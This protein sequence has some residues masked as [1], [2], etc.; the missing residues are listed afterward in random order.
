MSFLP[1]GALDSVIAPVVCLNVLA[2][3]GITAVALGTSSRR[4]PTNRPPSSGQE[5]DPADDKEKKMGSVVAAACIDDDGPAATFSCR[6]KVDVFEDDR[7]CAAY[8]PAN[9]GVLT[10]RAAMDATGDVAAAL[11]YDLATAAADAVRRD[12]AGAWVPLHPGPGRFVSLEDLTVDTLFGVRLRV[13]LRLIGMREAHTGESAGPILAATFD[14]TDQAC[15]DPAVARGE[16]RVALT[17]IA[18]TCAARLLAECCDAYSSSSSAYSLSSKHEVRN[19]A[20][21]VG[22]P[23]GGGAEVRIAEAAVRSLAAL[24]SLNRFA[25]FKVAADASVVHF[26]ASKP[27]PP[28]GRPPGQQVWRRVDALLERRVAAASADVPRPVLARLMS[29]PS[30]SHRTVPVDPSNPWATRLTAFDRETLSW[31][32][33]GPDLGLVASAVRGVVVGPEVGEDDAHEE[34]ARAQPGDPPQGDPTSPPGGQTPPPGGQTP[35]QGDPTPPPGGQTRPDTTRS[36]TTAS[37]LEAHA[38]DDARVGAIRPPGVVSDKDAI[39]HVIGDLDG[40]D[41][42]LFG[43]LH[44]LELIEVGADG[45]IAWLGDEHVWVVQCGDQIDSKRVRAGSEAFTPDMDL[46]VLLLTDYLAYISGGH[47]VSMVG[48]HEMMN[49]Y[50]DYRY[51]RD[52]HAH[53]GRQAMFGYDGLLGRVLQ[54][55]NVLFRVND[56]LFSHAGVCEAA[57]SPSDLGAGGLDAFVD[58]TNA[59]IRNPLAFD[60][61]LHDLSYARMNAEIASRYAPSA[62]QKHSAENKRMA[63]QAELERY[64]QGVQGVQGVHAFESAWASTVMHDDIGVLFT[65]RLKPGSLMRSDEPAVSDALRRNGVRL[66]VTG[67]NKDYETSTITL[68]VEDGDTGTKRKVV[69]EKIVP[70]VV[71]QGET[72][73]VMTDALPLTYDRSAVASGLRFLKVH[74]DNTTGDVAI[75]CHRFSCGDTC[76]RVL[77]KGVLDERL[78]GARL[79]NGSSLWVANVDDQVISDGIALFNFVKQLLPIEVAAVDAHFVQKAAADVA[80]AAAMTTST[81]SAKKAKDAAAKAVANAPEKT[82]VRH[83]RAAGL[84]AGVN[85][86]LALYKFA[87]KYTL[88]KIREDPRSPMSQLSVATTFKTWLAAVMRIAKKD[89]VYAFAAAKAR[90]PTA[91]DAWMAKDAVDAVWKLRESSKRLRGYIREPYPVKW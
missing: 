41:A 87:S 52:D 89:I 42:I 70:G 77:L 61:E 82:R 22:R 45:S 37:A 6:G 28:S 3:A 78:G 80:A 36:T 46:H 69:N 73:L 71:R 86:I 9:K 20:F 64:I 26:V 18:A 8:G 2:M 30:P 59:L 50:G 14:A 32:A 48:N 56:V 27:P 31:V 76:P 83:S 60:R 75:G 58:R 10:V 67:H 4:L 24:R 29:S 40:V 12:C 65:R 17:R 51:V 21:L 38:A 1:L 85:D 74:W 68:V 34:P 43:L 81:Q 84:Q 49:V 79:R 19:V 91:V 90:G 47:F 54:S 33:L 16:G 25:V 63:A 57:L 23:D 11:A 88:P 53:I 35:P 62:I 66:Q 13:F 15:I 7:T 5:D 44:H 55:R 39:V 72:G